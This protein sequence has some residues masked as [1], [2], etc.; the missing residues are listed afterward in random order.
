MKISRRLLDNYA[1]IMVPGTKKEYK[2]KLDYD[3]FNSLL[4]HTQTACPVRDDFKG[5]RSSTEGT[6]YTSYK[7][8]VKK[9]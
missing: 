3:E 7:L 6:T 9:E 8:N 2:L 4:S 1:I 5:S